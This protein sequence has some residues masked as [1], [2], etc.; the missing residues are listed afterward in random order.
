[1]IAVTIAPVLTCR[2]G[3]EHTGD[4]R[5]EDWIKCQCD[6]DS[7]EAIVPIGDEHVANQFICIECAETW[8]GSDGAAEARASRARGD[9]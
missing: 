4:Y 9:K 8:I 2:H 1:M 5:Y 6:H 7:P 3:H